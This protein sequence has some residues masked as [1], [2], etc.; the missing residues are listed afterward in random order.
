MNFFFILSEKQPHR[1]TKRDKYA[2]NANS[3]IRI[4]GHD[5]GKKSLLIQEDDTKKNLQKYTNTLY[6]FYLNFC[7]KF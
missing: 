7:H 4:N 5:E 6:E 3:Q 1:H 2:E